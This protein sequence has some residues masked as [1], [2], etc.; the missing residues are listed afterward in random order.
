MT[1]EQYID[2]K[3]FVIEQ[4]Y[5]K[6]IDFYDEEKFLSP[7]IFALEAGWVIC[8]SGMKNQI[9]E[10]I[11]I[12][13]RAAINECMLVSSVFGHKGKANAIQFIW[14]KRQTLFARYLARR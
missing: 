6:D 1:P 7:E 4:G 9:A 8:N 3:Q 5:V 14:D 13:V 11:W 12:K 10:R 2:L